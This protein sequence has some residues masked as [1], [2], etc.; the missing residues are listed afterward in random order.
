VVW[1]GQSAAMALDG[2]AAD[3]PVVVGG[4]AVAEECRTRR[5]F[6]LSDVSPIS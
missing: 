4:S 6:R 2:G 3:V 1:S 5:A